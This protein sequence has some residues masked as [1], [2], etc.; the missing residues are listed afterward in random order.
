M[1]TFSIE[2]RRNGSDASSFKQYLTDIAKIPL[3]SEPEEFEYAVKAKNG[4]ADA[5]RIL[6][7]CNL[8]FVVSV[9]KQSVD[10]V[11]KLEDLVNEG[12]L[13]LIIAAGKYDPTKGFKFISYA[14]WH[15]RQRINQFKAEHS[16]MIRL[17]GN[18]LALMSK[19]RSA[20][21]TLEQVLDRQPSANEIAEYMG[22]DDVKIISQTINLSLGCVYSLDKQIDD[23]FTL[24]DVLPMNNISACDSTLTMTDRSF[25]L[26]R[27]LSK[28][29]PRHEIIIRLY[30]G[31]SDHKPLTLEEIGNMLDITRE[32]VRQIR[33]KSIIK[34]KEL[35]DESP[36]DFNDLF[37]A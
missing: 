7:E 26:K 34:L 2:L 9:A 31:L 15:I 16:N 35:I 13:G 10:R 3:L 30:Y 18:K 1:R 28:L 17:P 24:L 6:I 14:V 36:I 29:K 37:N 8:R 11:T 20:T 19:V 12:N 33:D 25:M 21:A 27:L 22:V 5:L 32:A 4:D 23:D